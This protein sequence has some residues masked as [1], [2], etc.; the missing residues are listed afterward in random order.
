VPRASLAYADSRTKDQQIASHRNVAAEDDD[1]R[2]KRFQRTKV[3]PLYDQS[4]TVAPSAADVARSE[5]NTFAT[6]HVHALQ[7]QITGGPAGTARNHI[8]LRSQRN[9]ISE[10]L[11]SGA[12]KSEIG[13]YIS[14]PKM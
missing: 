4:A 5:A 9:T 10:L 8:D 11:D 2:G 6:T 7:R 3:N 12:S 14:T 13:V 1:Y